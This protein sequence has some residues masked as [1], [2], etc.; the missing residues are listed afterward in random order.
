MS[1]R[2]RLLGQILNRVTQPIE[3]VTDHAANRAKR[4]AVQRSAVGQRVFGR[5][6]RRVTVEELDVTLP[7]RTLP[8]LVYRPPAVGDGPRPLVVNYHGG[9]W[10]QGNTEQ[11]GW[12]A[13]RVAARTGA[14]V[15][16]PSYRFAPEHPFPAAVDDAWETLR[17]LVGH[18]TALGID[19]ERVAVMGDSAG[20]NLAAVTAL[21][22]RDEGDPRLRAQVLI[23]PAVEMYEKYASELRMPNAPVLTSANMRTFV[24][25]YLQDAYG[26]DDWRAS[27]L[28]ATKHEDLPAAFILTAEF[29]PLLDNGSRYRDALQRAGV[30]VR[31][32]M[33]PDAI[34]G[35]VSLPGLVGTPA[36]QALD[37]ITDFLAER[38]AP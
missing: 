34:H 2:V 24:Q 17:W 33:Y 36:R 20:G 8:A 19:P 6:D 28:R 4:L 30:P 15:V 22:S 32:R 13:S 14:V 21:T 38:L 35:F 10:V 37:D 29:D 18:A 23:Y 3:E 12:L 1:V 31:Y 25:L 11:S 5:P 9:G 7:G 27:P 16:S 26:T